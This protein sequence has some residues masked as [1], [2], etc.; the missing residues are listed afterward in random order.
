MREDV[1]IFSDV[2]GVDEVIPVQEFIDRAKV[3]HGV[4]FMNLEELLALKC[5][6]ARD[7]DIDDITL[8]E[9]YLK[10]NT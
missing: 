10:N 2:E 6:N 9:E 8:M 3:I 5:Y 1:E 4:P 7:K